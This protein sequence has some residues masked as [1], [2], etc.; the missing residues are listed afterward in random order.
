MKQYQISEDLLLLLVR[1][2]LHEETDC[3]EEIQ[4]ELQKKLDCIINRN[5]YSQYKNAPTPEEQEKARQEY[6]DRKG[7]FSNFRW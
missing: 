4:M 1:Y 3:Q 2:H 7:I 6:L 5:L